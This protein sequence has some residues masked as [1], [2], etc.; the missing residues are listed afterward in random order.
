VQVIS[1]DGLELAVL[2]DGKQSPSQQLIK[3]R[4]ER[5]FL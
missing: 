5:L 3:L 1:V 4:L 2:R